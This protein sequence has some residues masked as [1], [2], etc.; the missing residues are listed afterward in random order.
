MSST[1]PPSGQ[2]CLYN[3]Q[4]EYACPVASPVKEGFRPAWVSADAETSA[5]AERSAGGVPVP[6]TEW[7]SQVRESRGRMAPAQ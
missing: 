5:W 7:Q 4:G 1:A 3:A 2:Q 6:A